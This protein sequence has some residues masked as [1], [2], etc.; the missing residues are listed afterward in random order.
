MPWLTV[1]PRALP[2]NS[3][4]KPLVV[5]LC[6]GEVLYLPALWFHS[7][8]QV[9]DNNGLC[10]AV[11]YWYNMDF[12]GPLYPLFNFLRHITMIEDGRAEDIEHDDS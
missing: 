11:N 6:P 12:T 7:V 5:T 3:P 9:P 4:C 8:A 2:K 1:D 10:I